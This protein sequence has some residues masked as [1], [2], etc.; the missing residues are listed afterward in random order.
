MNRYLNKIIIVIIFLLLLLFIISSAT[1]Y[2]NQ[3]TN[4]ISNKLLRIH[5][6]ANSDAETDQELKIK[7]RNSILNYLKTL[8]IENSSKNNTINI[9]RNNKNNIKLIAQNTIYENNFDYPISVEF[10]KYNSTK[11]ES[12]NISIPSGIY[13]S[14]IIKIGNATGHNWWSIIYPSLCFTDTNS[15][16]LND[17][18]IIDND[19]NNN[20]ND[21]DTN[22][23]KEILSKE[24]YDLIINNS[25]KKIF[26]FKIVD[27]IE[28]IIHCNQK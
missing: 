22:T 23:L 6:I 25:S 19:N 3:L 15:Y 11:K 5:V 12:K 13:D 17:S 7:V 18:T 27:F 14:L 10:T 21:S 16:T 8:N 4:D 24:E 28:S 1:F 2:S 20:N 9:L 26:K